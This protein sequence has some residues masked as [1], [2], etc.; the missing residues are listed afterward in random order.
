MWG[1]EGSEG[2]STGAGGTAALRRGVGGRVSGGT[3]S[4][5]AGRLISV[6][7]SARPGSRMG[8]T[9]FWVREVYRNGMANSG[10]GSVTSHPGAGSQSG[11]KSYLF[12]LDTVLVLGE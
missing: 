1:V 5:A 7:G 6:L 9:G 8:A 2:G 10:G 3:A 11:R 12:S 4:G